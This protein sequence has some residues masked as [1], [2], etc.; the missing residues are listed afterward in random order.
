VWAVNRLA[1]EQPKAI[2]GLLAAGKAL[3]SAQRGL[4]RGATIDKMRDAE[5]ELRATLSSLDEMVAQHNLSAP[6]R[7][8]AIDTLRAAATADETTRAA[9]R[10]GRLETDL[11]P[12]TGFGALGDVKLPKGTPRPARAVREAKRASQREVQAAHKRQQQLRKQGE[13]L[14]AAA[15]KAERRA[16]DL[17]ARADQAA[18]SLGA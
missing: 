12:G 8:R 10:A 18:A 16:R 3:A 1:R 14:R 2:A 9:L 17:R 13:R 11:D 4:L 15:E 7:H 6:A 5:A